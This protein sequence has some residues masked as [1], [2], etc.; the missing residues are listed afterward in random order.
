MYFWAG[1]VSWAGD[2]FLKGL[3]FARAWL[4][5]ALLGLGGCVSIGPRSIEM[6]RTDYNNAIQ[7]TDG[8]QLLLNI[9]RQRYNDP[10]MFLEVSSISSSKSFSQNINLSS[11]LTSAFAPQSFS[12]GFGGSITDSPLVF[13][14]PNTG[15]RFVHQILTPIDLRT[16]TLLLQSGWSIERVLLLAGDSINGIRNT[17]AKDTPYAVLAE[18]LRTLQRNN[19]LSFALQV[20][21]AL[22]VLSIIPSSDVVDVS[23]YKEV[24]EILKIRADGAPIRIAQGIGDPG[25]S[26]QHIQLATRPLYSTLYF[27]SNGVDVPVAAIEAR[28]VQERGAVGGLFDP[29]LGK[30][31]H[32]RSSTIEP[33]NFALRVRYRNEWFYLDETDLDSRTTFTLISALF[34]LQSGDTSRM[35]PLVS[36]SPAR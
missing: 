18:K 27:L 24:C 21:G 33:R 7:Q 28:T 26:S 36:L 1:R 25:F 29:S 4:I 2:I 6:G 20:E 22:T 5:A 30:L 31:F 14:S 32:V 23:A 17:E 19:K 3:F 35:T 12:G 13:Y 9:V 34:M 16:I 11:F 8:E 10:V 15:E